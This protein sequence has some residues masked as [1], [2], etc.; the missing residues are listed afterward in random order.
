MGV[1][2]LFQRLGLIA[3][4]L[5]LQAGCVPEISPPGGGG[6]GGPAATDADGDGASADEDCDDNDAWVYP[7]APELCDG[8]DNDCDDEID[9]ELPTLYVDA[10][11]DG[12]GD[13]DSGEPVTACEEDGYS[14]YASDC[15]DDDASIFPGAEELCDGLDNDCDDE[16]DEGED[17]N[18]QYIDA[19]GDGYGDPDGDTV[20]SCEEYAG[21]SLYGTDCDD[22]DEDINPDAFDSCDG[23]DND[24]D[25]LVDEDEGASVSQVDSEADYD[26][27]NDA[28]EAGEDCI[29]VGP[30]TYYENIYLY[31]DVLITG[32][33]GPEETIIS[34][35][36]DDGPVLWLAQGVTNDTVIS[37]FTLQ[38]GAGY[39]VS[40]K[41]S[42]GLTYEYTYGGGIYAYYST[43]TLKNLVVTNNTLPEYKTSGTIYEYSFGGG[44][45]LRPYSTDGEVL[46]LEDVE[47]TNNEGF[48]GADIYLYGYYGSAEIRRLWAHDSYASG[49]AA[50]YLHYSISADYNM[51]LENVIIDSF[52]QA[53]NGGAIQVYYANVEMN[54]IAVVDTVGYSPVQIAFTSSI[55]NEV[56]IRNS[57]LAYNDS[58]YGV[59]V[60]NNGTTSDFSIKYSAL[61]EPDSIYETDGTNSA[62]STNLIGDEPGFDSFSQDGDGTNDELTL[63]SSSPL[64]DAG[65]PS[66]GYND[67]DGT[68]NDI[69][70]YGGRQ[71]TW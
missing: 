63:S 10:D 56:N 7:G 19:D 4:A 9:E 17:G 53:Q 46:I 1:A 41:S 40:S 3:F 61:Y 68:R 69:G 30:G 67:N 66:T 24:C 11:G 70:P 26:T 2:L 48:Y 29:I 32:A 36:Y 42:T 21:Y 52:S 13:T 8:L 43:P 71:G 38:E 45:Y 5:A 57:V 15:D 51:L 31:S 64:I 16:I 44:A 65:D 59:Y 18:I 6:G 62:D 49:I 60:G 54:N 55:D 23:V 34:G 12:F 22:D 14:P 33:E 20:E 25:D 58:T 28:L 35:L 27:I 47:F 50:L 39:L 37:G